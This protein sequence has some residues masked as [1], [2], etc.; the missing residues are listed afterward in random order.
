MPVVDAY[1]PTPIYISQRTR[2]ILIVLGFIAISYLC[3][4]APSVP[5][6]FLIGATV[7]LVLSFPT[8]LLSH[9]IPR[10]LAITIVA[11]GTLLFGII[12]VALLIPFA[13]NEI[14]QFAD[15]FPATVE[16]LQKL[17]RRA[18]EDMYA[19]GWIEKNPD[20]VFDDIQ[21]G[22][23]NAGESI[24]SNFAT[25][26]L[27]TLTRSVN[28]L[29]TTF[30]V[31]F[32]AIYLLIDIP[33]FKDTYIRMW[34]PQ[35][36]NDAEE[37]WDTIGNSLS[38]YLGGLLISLTIQGVMAFIGLTLMGIPY[39]L[40]LGF[41]MA[42]TAILPYIGAYLGAI[43]SVLIALSISWQMA[44]A[45]IFLYVLINQ[46][47]SNLITPRIQGNAVRV[48]PLLIFFSVIIGSRLFGVVGALM[49][50][51]SLAVLRV[52]GEFFWLRLRVRGEQQT[53][54]SAMRND[55]V[56]ERIEH[57]QKELEEAQ[58]D[59]PGP[60]DPTVNDPV[61]TPSRPPAHD[62]TL[63]HGRSTPIGE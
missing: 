50:V 58:F 32:V 12:G 59:E 60:D 36:R 42:V 2:L 41:W 61:P 4:R 30:G 57:R 44:V 14:T 6:L 27:D 16:E 31:I 37:L 28:I 39:A 53:L 48:H 34:A 5:E 26:L 24:V 46:V 10:K 52:I 33:R 23:I 18:L 47:E 49:A 45:T 17:L 40:L 9:Y 35:Y 19:R 51:P 22:V 20:Q 56:E 63:H 54:L 7:A 29:I 15:S 55:T 11:V 62:P 8:R 38:R 25:N 3:Y 1:S 43:P 21:S 13:V